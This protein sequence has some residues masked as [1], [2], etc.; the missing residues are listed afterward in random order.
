[1]VYIHPSIMLGT[2]WKINIIILHMTCLALKELFPVCFNA[3][4]DL[5]LLQVELLVVLL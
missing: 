5:I 3:A 4:L 2:E 1:M